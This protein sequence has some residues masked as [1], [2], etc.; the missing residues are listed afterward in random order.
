MHEGLFKKYTQ[1]ILAR[2]DVKQK[3]ILSLLEKTGVQVEE[4]EIILSKK[5][6]ILSLSSVKKAALI[7]KGGKEA[8]NS[9]GYTLQV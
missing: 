2:V 9:L 8:V 5:T 7:Q 6:V 4:S 3:I 1:Q